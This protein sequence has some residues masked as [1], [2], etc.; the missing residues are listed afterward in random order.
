ME[1]ETLFVLSATFLVF[2]DLLLLSRSKPHEKKV[3]YGFYAISVASSLVIASYLLLTQAFLKDDFTLRE[4]YSHSSSAMPYWYKISATWAGMGG[5][6]LFFTS[7]LSAFYFAYRFKTLEKKTLLNIRAHMV[8]DVVLLFFVLLTLLMDP[9]ERVPSETMDGLGLNP[10]LQSFWM[11]IHPPILFVGYALA[12]PPFALALSRLSVMASSSSQMQQNNPVADASSAGTVGDTTSYRAMNL[13]LGS[14]WLTLTLG[15]ALGGL[16]AYEVLGWGGYWAWDPVETASLIPWITLTAYFHISPF[17]RRSRSL[18]REFMVFVT[19]SLTLFAMFVTRGGLLE[20]VHAFG[21]SPVGPAFLLFILL[22]AGYFLGL[23]R[24]VRRALLT[25]EIDRSSL[26]SISLAVGF[27]SLMALMIVC[28]AG[29]VIPL[30]QGLVSGT[31]SSMEAEFFNNWSFPFGLS[32]VAA[33]VG[34]SMPSKSSLRRYLAMIAVALVVGVG[35]ALL[36]TPTPDFRANLGLPLLGL[37][38]VVIGNRIGLLTPRLRRSYPLVARYVL[39]LGIVLLLVGVFVSFTSAEESGD[40][41]MA[42]NTAVVTSGL[43]VEWKNSTVHPGTGMICLQGECYPEHSAFEMDVGINTGGNLHNGVLRM[44]LYPAHGLVS[45]PLIVSTWSGDI[46]VTMGVTES[47]RAALIHALSGLTMPPRNLT[48]NV[49][50]VPFVNLVWIGVAL[51][52]TAI[53][54]RL[55]KNVLR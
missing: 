53:A 17:A 29:V 11:I 13:L 9:F 15:I 25:L 5:S 44:R 37:A 35:L 40:I 20:S 31:P 28:L 43:T 36:G 33:L 38:L 26:L 18:S 3:E 41:L 2:F 23:K 10:L 19:F 34:C 12:V 27:L 22:L 49:K 1:I 50:T 24:K 45:E 14:A 21:A 52:C 30:A 51:V 8:M 7:L 55:V 39:H 4:V 6:M 46:Y 16:W 47:V 54:V 48:I 32:F 42:P